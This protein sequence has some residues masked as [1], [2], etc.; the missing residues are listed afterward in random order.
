[1]NQ[2]TSKFIRRTARRL[3]V[4]YRSLK[5]RWNE[6]PRPLRGAAR[7]RFLHAKTFHD[8]EEA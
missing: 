8:L 1:M 7:D 4:G 2:R 3:K 6:I 5:D